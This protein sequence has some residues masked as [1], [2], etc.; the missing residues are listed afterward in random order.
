MIAKNASTQSG[1]QRNDDQIWAQ[2]SCHWNDNG[3]QDSKGAPSSSGR[4]AQEGCC[5][6]KSA[7]RTAPGMLLDAMMF[8]T[9]TSVCSRSRQ[10]PL[11]VQART[12][13]MMAGTMAAIPLVTPSMK[14]RKRI[15]PR[16]TNC[17]KAQSNAANPPQ[18]RA[19]P[20]LQLPNAA[21]K[22]P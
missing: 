21:G 9:N 2:S 1:R 11:M 14:S 22:L 7:G 19:W 20:A 5:H 4:K 16:G 13:I 18:V 3:N 6:K 12:K 15:N 17:T 8:F 10:T